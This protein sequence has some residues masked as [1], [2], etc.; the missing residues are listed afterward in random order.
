LAVTVSLVLALAVAV[1]LM[2]RYTGLRIGQAAV[3][4]AFGFCLAST[5][6]A[7]NINQFINSLI[8]GL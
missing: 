8:H 4:I 3:C 1:F 6:I 7:P 5:S 2:C